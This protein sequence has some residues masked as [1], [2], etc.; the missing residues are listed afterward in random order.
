MVV[1]L[2]ESGCGCEAW[3]QKNGKQYGICGDGHTCIC[4]STPIT[5]PEN[6]CG[7]R[8]WCQK[9]GHPGGIC[10]DGYTCICSPKIEKKNKEYV[11]GQYKLPIINDAD[12]DFNE[13]MR[14]RLIDAYFKFYPQIQSHFNHDARK[15]VQI[16]IDPNY[17]G[18][19]YASNGQ[20][21][22]S[23]THLKNHPIPT[24]VLIHEMM[25]IVQSYPNGQ[26]GWLVEGIADYVR[27]KYGREKSGW[28]LTS[29]NSNQHYTDSYRITAR[30]LVW[31]EHKIKRNIV[32]RL[33]RALRQ[34]QY[35]N[36]K[37][38]SKITG[39]NVDQLWKDYASNPSL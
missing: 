28:E 26:P 23:A 15:D 21:V 9:R 39:K 10:G 32:S 24:G 3:C 11:R 25:H 8:A 29:F 17:D 14:K 36:G 31:L 7:C 30:F 22:I 5:D 1:R 35:D 27:W 20:I 2:V 34:N 37:L 12:N 6:G 18:I 33:D 38:W 4:S 13:Q 19:A 16:K